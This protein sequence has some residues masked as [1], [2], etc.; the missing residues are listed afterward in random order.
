MSNIEP[1]NE[2]DF[3]INTEEIENVHH[4]ADFVGTL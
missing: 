2:N 4:G 3:S 1:K